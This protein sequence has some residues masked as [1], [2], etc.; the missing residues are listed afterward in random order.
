MPGGVNYNTH[1]HAQQQQQAV[2]ASRNPLQYSQPSLLSIHQQ[3]QA[4]AAHHAHH[5]GGSNGFGNIHSGSCSGLSNNNNNSLSNGAFP[6]YNN[7]T[8]NGGED[9]QISSRGIGVTRSDGS[10]PDGMHLATRGGNGGSISGQ[11]TP[12]EPETSYHK[13]SEEGK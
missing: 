7:R 12:K 13:A 9:F 5:A 8:A 3:Q 11:S 4:V 10:G 6:D 1:Q 2:M